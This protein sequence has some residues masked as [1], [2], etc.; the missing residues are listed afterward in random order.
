M[1]K[2][3]SSHKLAS[4]FLESTTIA[5]TS[6]MPAQIH[7]ALGTDDGEL[8]LTWLTAQ[9]CPASKVWYQG[10]RI[11]DATT[12]TYTVPRRWWQPRI[13]RWVHHATLA[14]IAS[15]GPFSY[16]A[17]DNSTDG[18]AVLPRPVDARAPPHRGELPVT[19][20]LMADVG[21]VEILGF[22]TWQALDKRTLPGAE[23]DADLAVH[24]GD[25]SYAGMDTALP[26]LNVTKDDEWEPLW[27]LYGLAHQNFTQRRVCATAV[28][29]GARRLC[30]TPRAESVPC[31]R[32]PP[33]QTRL[34]WATT[35]RGTTGPP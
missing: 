31:V 18:C 26:A 2:L 30:P 9:E 23:L 11:A 34:A 4:T 21:S 28:V 13:M 19:A 5:G 15:R 16:V 20:A 6:D 22:A 10:G 3:A 17:G 29:E 24:A 27:D 32:P 35:K 14:G 8:T 33:W 1:T 7:L 12:T 25:V